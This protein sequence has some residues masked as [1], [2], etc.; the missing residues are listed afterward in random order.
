M[1][2]LAPAV[3]FSVLAFSP[4][5]AADADTPHVEV[6]A[7]GFPDAY[8][9]AVART[10]ESARQVC[11]DQYGFDMP[12]VI[13]LNADLGPKNTVRLFND[14]ADR[15]SLSVKTEQNL[16]RPKTS[17]IFHIYGLC[18]EVAHLAMY[19]PIRDHSWL[20]TAGAEGWAHWLGSQIVDAVYEQHGEDLWP[21]KYYYREDG[22]RRLNRQLAASEPTETVRVPVSRRPIVWAVVGGEQ[23][24]ATS[25]SVS[26]FAFR[27]WRMLV[28]IAHLKNNLCGVY[29]VLQFHHC[30]KSPSRITVEATWVGSKRGCSGN[31]RSRARSLARP[32]PR[33]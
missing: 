12:E 32:G 14:G 16:K 33:A 13:H 28:I 23:R 31:V 29:T 24:P 7:K 19:R 17:G 2:R 9:A 6:S 26:P 30:G 10:I 22:T 11:I 4:S 8:Q 15:F 18:H 25:S 21:D 5:L 3:L 20:T 27:T 1:S